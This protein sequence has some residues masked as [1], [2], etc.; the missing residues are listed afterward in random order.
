MF[1][2]LPVFFGRRDL[3]S[4]LF[5]MS[6]FFGAFW[7]YS[8][9]KIAQAQ[10]LFWVNGAYVFSS[11]YILSNIYFAWLY[12]VKQFRFTTKFKWLTVLFVGLFA[13]LGF[14]GEFFAKS[15][16]ED[17]VVTYGIG[18]HLFLIYFVFGMLVIL[19]G[20]LRSVKLGSWQDRMRSIYYMLGIFFMLILGI[21]IVFIVPVITGTMAYSKYTPFGYPVMIALHFYSIFRYQLLDIR[22]IIKRG[23]V[24]LVTMGVFSLLFFMPL[25]LVKEV[26][27][28]TAIQELL[29]LVFVSFFIVVFYPRFIEYLN[30]LTDRVFF[31]SSYDYQLVTA[32]YDQRLLLQR[33]PKDIVVDLVNMID[34]ALKPSPLVGY[35]KDEFG[36]ILS[37]SDGT[38]QVLS[39]STL[40]FKELFDSSKHVLLER[41]LEDYDERAEYELVGCI[42]SSKGIQAIL[43]MGKRLSDVAYQVKDYHLLQ[44]LLNRSAV[45]LDHVSHYDDII[46]YSQMLSRFNLLF[47]MMKQNVGVKTLLEGLLPLIRMEFVGNLILHFDVKQDLSVLFC[48]DTIVCDEDAVK[49]LE[50]RDFLS[51]KI[52]TSDGVLYERV[53]VFSDYPELKMFCQ[54]HEFKSVIC[55]TLDSGY[56]D[57]EIL[58]SFSKVL[59]SESM[60]FTLLIASFHQS[61]ISLYRRVYLYDKIIKTKH[62]NEEVLQQML[63]GI[64]VLDSDG[65]IRHANRELCRIL[66]KGHAELLGTAINDLEADRRVVSFLQYAFSSA[67]ET[68]FEFSMGTDLTL[69]GSSVKLSYGQEVETVCLLADISDFR[70]LE[71]KLEHSDRLASLSSLSLGVSKEIGDP[72]ASLKSLMHELDDGWD[73]VQAIEGRVKLISEHVDHINSL[74]RSLLRLGKPNQIHFAR[75]NMVAL[76][77]EAHGLISGQLTMKKISFETSI[78]DALWIEG[79]Y[80]QL[81]QV[82]L[83]LLM[84]AMQAY[85][86]D[87]GVIRFSMFEEGTDCVLVIRDEGTG[88]SDEDLSRVF[89]PFFTRKEKHNGLGMTISHRIVQDH[90]GS[91]VYRQEDKGVS[92][93]LRLPLVFPKK[94]VN[95]G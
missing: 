64:L 10:D 43:C 56:G 13:W 73:D 82:L 79:D 72:I 17:F 35:F 54:E 95:R 92:V 71:R 57:P 22:I 7:V 53:D 68:G 48:D 67:G 58:V 83:N 93:E 45:A 2:I 87:G 84:N 36:R 5:S 50:W 31:R 52:L 39:E 44:S 41:P 3:G 19:W 25:F 18:R 75:L 63:V 69:S 40:P 94:G 90:Y 21:I 16:T 66:G 74:C 33:T 65:V 55:L 1:G 46:R 89:D 6:S 23:F 20:A 38:I 14:R 15:I 27:D 12:P 34:M 29:L 51:R 28:V 47:V 85:D 61:V 78:P 24:Y 86:E 8:V 60:I 80:S 42:R 76:I 11:L 77:Q 37:F 62:Y 70:K 88:L 4:F 26:L 30:Q 59:I 81:L 32:D 49:R 9:L 91:I